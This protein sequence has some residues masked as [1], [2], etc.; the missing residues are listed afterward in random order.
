M[1]SFDF[2]GLLIPAEKA[3]GPRIMELTRSSDEPWEP[4]RVQVTES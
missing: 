3:L 2:D 1:N 4:T